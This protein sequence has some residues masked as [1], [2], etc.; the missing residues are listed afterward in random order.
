MTASLGRLVLYTKCLPD[1]VAFYRDHFGYSERS[2]EGDRITELVPPG[3]GATLLLHPAARG[4]RVGQ[5]Q[6]KLVF[7][8]DDVTRFAEVSATRGLVF[9]P[10]HDGGGYEFAN[11]KDPSGNSV[12]ISSRSK[13]IPGQGVAA[14]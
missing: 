3:T 11:T 8:V 7:D 9:G 2:R 5:A 1:M 13:H 12:Q 6:V 14:D 4:Q 10:V